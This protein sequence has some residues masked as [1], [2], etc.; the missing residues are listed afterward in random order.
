MGD[1]SPGV[2]RLRHGWGVEQR[3]CLSIAQFGGQCDANSFS[4][5]DSDLGSVPI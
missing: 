5:S 2:E 3:V 4:R 1:S